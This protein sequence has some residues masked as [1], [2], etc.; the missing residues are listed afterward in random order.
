[1]HDQYEYGRWHRAAHHEKQIGAYPWR[2]GEFFHKA[3]PFPNGPTVPA[4]AGSGW[5][6]WESLY[7]VN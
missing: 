2:I 3:F 4:P 1:M 6:S 5:P 7:W